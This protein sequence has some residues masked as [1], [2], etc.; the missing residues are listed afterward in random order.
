MGGA[1]A[2]ESPSDFRSGRSAGRCCADR[3]SRSNAIG[4]KLTQIFCGPA[5]AA[6]KVRGSA[7]SR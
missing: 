3:M 7:T 5:R 1:A 4:S 2:F 6:S